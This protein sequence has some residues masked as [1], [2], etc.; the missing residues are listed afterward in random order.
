MNLV[1][2]FVE[3]VELCGFCH[4]VLIHEEGGLDLLVT[5]FTQK[6]ETIGD[7]SLVEVDTVVCEEVA[8]VA[9]D[10]CTCAWIV[11]CWGRKWR[12]REEY[13]DQD[14]LHPTEG[15]LHGERGSRIFSQILHLDRPDAMFEGPGYRPGIRDEDSKKNA[16]G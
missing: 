6:V 11:E 9:G 15:G 2:L 13:L 14:P 5:L 10:F 1:K 12:R 4:Y 8:T 7:Q 3:L 16:G